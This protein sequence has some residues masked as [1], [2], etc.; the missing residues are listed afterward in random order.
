MKTSPIG[1]DFAH[2]L[3]QS[4]PADSAQAHTEKT[5]ITSQQE[6]REILNAHIEEDHADKL[7]N[8]IVP[9]ASDDD[10]EW[11][12]IMADT[13]ADTPKDTADDISGKTLE[14]TLNETKEQTWEE[15][16][17]SVNAIPGVQVGDYA[18]KNASTIIK[19]ETLSTPF[20]R[21]RLDTSRH[22]I[23]EENMFTARININFRDFWCN[24]VGAE[25]KFESLYEFNRAAHNT[26]R[27]FL[28]GPFSSKADLEQALN[29]T[30]KYFI[31]ILDAHGAEGHSLDL[32]RTAPSGAPYI[33]DF[34]ADASPLTYNNA[35]NTARTIA[36]IKQ[37]IASA[38]QN[39]GTALKD[40]ILPLLSIQLGLAS[41]AIDQNDNR[42]IVF[43]NDIGEFCFDD[44]TN[45][46][47]LWSYPN[48]P[49]RPSKTLRDGAATYEDVKFITK[50]LLDCALERGNISS[51]LHAL[52]QDIFDDEI[53]AAD[54]IASIS[55]S[56]ASIA[57]PSKLMTAAELLEKQETQGTWRLNTPKP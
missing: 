30:Q 7:A 46:L 40:I 32:S 10:D 37:N 23:S 3:D 21:M 56:E 57:K 11:D 42:H 27:S 51:D 44:E 1:R 13:P 4:A 41:K 14:E 20:F 33:L 36:L 31:H 24:E 2:K 49:E 15:L 22:L 9:E 17:D 47:T 53:I 19:D 29:E 6:I 50:R 5:L 34:D 45:D 39:L 26:E 48:D 38:A 18:N 8:F 25:D 12:L 16:K 54:S 55:L 35:L 43:H 28:I 52:Y